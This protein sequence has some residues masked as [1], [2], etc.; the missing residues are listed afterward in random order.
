MLQVNEMLATGSSYAQI[1]RAL[2]ANGHQISLDSVRNHANKHFPA[3]NVA[4]ARYRD[5]L[6]RR[7]AEREIDFVNGVGTAITPLAY[8]EAM[9][10]KGFERLV[11]DDT[12]VS[13]EMGLKAAEKLH[14][15]I[16]AVD[17]HAQ[18]AKFLAEMGRVIDVV[19]SLLPQSSWPELRA[20]L[21]DNDVSGFDHS[22]PETIELQ[23]PPGPDEVIVVPIDT[24]DGGDDF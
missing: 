17:P 16:G 14:K 10:V 7:A 4:K 11:Q 5:I 18:N 12:E 1:V 22:E 24:D 23:E 8:L 19:K 21:R 15:A 2:A 3:Q 6:E 13:P 20:R 9:M